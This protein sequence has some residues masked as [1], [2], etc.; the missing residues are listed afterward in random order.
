MRR[1]LPALLG[2]FLLF[3]MAAADEVI[4]RDGTVLAADVTLVKTADGRELS[5]DR[6]YAVRLNG[7]RGVLDAAWVE[8]NLRFA[9]DRARRGEA[10]DGRVGVYLGRGV[11]PPS[12]IA[13]VRRLD[14]GK[15]APRLLFETDV[16]AKGL[17][18]LDVVIFP[19]GWAPSQR[20]VLGESGRTALAQFVNGG[21][22]YLGICAGGYLP[23]SDV[24]WKQE[25][26]AYPLALA[27]GK[28]VGPVPGLAPYPASQGVDLTLP[29]GKKMRALYA[30][31]S[32]FE[33]KGA[34][35]LASYPNGTAAAVAVR[36]GE[37]LLVLTGAHI[38]FR[39]DRDADLL[40]QDA[41]AAQ[42]KAGTADLFATFLARVA[43]KR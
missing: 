40:G 12:G 9:L 8:Q 7:D 23:C 2:L 16:T 41:W 13:V 43:P 18:G 25:N 11:F 1:L 5:R 42:V 32:S 21:G 3:S 30:G 19:G 27:D 33:I 31:G 39:D 17:T 36:H 14:E 4:L 20:D 29:G 34:E 38:E 24:V 35:S 15:R 26:F 37:G 10:A 22:N 6:V 28:A